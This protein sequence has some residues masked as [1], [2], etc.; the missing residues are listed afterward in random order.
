MTCYKLRIVYRNDEVMF[1]FT[2]LKEF[3]RFTRL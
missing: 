2:T 3:L 1:A